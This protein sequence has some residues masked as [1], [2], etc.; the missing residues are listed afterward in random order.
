MLET[1]SASATVCYES[2]FYIL[3]F[4]GRQHGRAFKNHIGHHCQFF[5]N[6]LFLYYISIYVY[7]THCKPTKL[8]SLQL[9]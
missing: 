3:P 1:A 6:R 2:H 9:P 7:L 4:E 5:Q 8:C